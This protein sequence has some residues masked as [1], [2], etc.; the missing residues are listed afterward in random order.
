M[1]QPPPPQLPPA[2]GG[3][4]L[5]ARDLFRHTQRSIAAGEARKGR[6]VLASLAGVRTEDMFHGSSLCLKHS[7]V[8]QG[9]EVSSDDAQNFLRMTGEPQRFLELGQSL[10]S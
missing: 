4:C 5:F 2:E 7:R 9:A 3:R 1:K 6:S 8:T 10:A